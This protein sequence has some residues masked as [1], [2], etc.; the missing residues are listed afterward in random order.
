MQQTGPRVGKWRYAWRQQLTA[1]SAYATRPP[2]LLECAWGDIARPLFGH[3]QAW[4][5]PKQCTIELELGP[6]A[7]SVARTQLLVFSRVV[8]AF[9][10][11][12]GY[13]RIPVPSVWA[14]RA[15]GHAGTRELRWSPWRHMPEW[16]K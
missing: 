10:W 8:A 9:C 12:C 2:A 15:W 14:L 5:D 1:F 11:G 6:Q 4:Q 3:T 16:Y 7:R 13:A